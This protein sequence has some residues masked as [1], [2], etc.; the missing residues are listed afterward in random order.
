MSAR[1][2]C[3]ISSAGDQ[4]LST[5]SAVIQVDSER[6]RATPWAGED[7]FCCTE[8]RDR[9]STV[10]GDGGEEEGRR[11]GQGG[12]GGGRG[13]EGGGRKRKRR[14]EEEEAEAEEEEEEEGSLLTSNE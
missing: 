6:D 8:L 13:G 11:K 10:K 12:G 1:K 5:A 14:R 7:L 9:R 2:C 3:E 4:V